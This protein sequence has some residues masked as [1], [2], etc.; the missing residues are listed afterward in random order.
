[1]SDIKIESGIGWAK[2]FVHGVELRQITGMVVDFQ[3]GQPPE[4]RVDLFARHSTIDLTGAVLKIGG[5]DMPN[6]LEKA[7]LDYLCAKYPNRCRE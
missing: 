5:V 6:D 7:L 2:C 1:M 4:V 3:P